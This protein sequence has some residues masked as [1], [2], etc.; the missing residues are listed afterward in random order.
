MHSLRL[1]AGCVVAA[2]LL[3]A[4]ISVAA[5]PL[6]A[7][8]PGAPGGLGAYPPNRPPTVPAPAGAPPPPPALADDTATYCQRNPHVCAVRQPDTHDLLLDRQRQ[9]HERM[10]AL[11][12][13]I[14]QGRSPPPR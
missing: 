13:E 4:P 3:A 6:G 8:P 10:R 12:L 11:E 1:I 5:P 14:E 2:G 9:F 7:Y